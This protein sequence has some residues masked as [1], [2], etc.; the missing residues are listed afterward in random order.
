MPDSVFRLLNLDKAGD[1]LLA[2][3]LF[4]TFTKFTDAYHA[5][6]LG[7]KMTT[8]WIVRDHYDDFDVAKMILAAEKTSSSASA[9]KRME[10]VLFKNWMAS[11]NTPD[12][13]F[14]TLKLDQ[15]GIDKLFEAPMFNYWMKFMD[16]YV[17][18][19]PA[20]NI[21]RTMLVTTYN[22]QDLWRLIEAAKNNPETKE[23]GAQRH[24]SSSLSLKSSR[25]TWRN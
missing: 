15:V 19:F 3:P 13:A 12:D 22:D 5:N 11:P 17:K 2:S 20:K 16:D 18:A 9:A 1:N 10:G 24:P 14:K 7:S 8:I 21:K 6:N 23:M 4:T 25:S